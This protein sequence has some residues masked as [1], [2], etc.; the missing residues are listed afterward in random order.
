MIESLGKPTIAVINGHALGGGLEFAL[1]CDFR[2][3]GRDSGTIG[4]PEIRLGLIPLGGGTQR[5]PRLIGRGRALELLLDGARIGA[6]E[7]LSIGLV[8]RVFERE[9]IDDGALAYARR[10]A[11]GPTRSIGLIKN[12]VYAGLETPLPAGLQ[13][14]RDSFQDLV[15]TEDM[16]EGILSF[17]ERREPHYTGR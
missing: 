16:V 12:C 14:E 2:F 15:R 13:I 1:A 10:L 9:K 4:L 11:Q 5:L 8:N 17:V 3:M 6:D 7:A